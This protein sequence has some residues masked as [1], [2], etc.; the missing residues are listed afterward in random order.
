MDNATLV[1]LFQTETDPKKLADLMAEVDKRLDRL[2]GH[3]I[4]RIKAQHKRQAEE[5][6]QII[7]T[8]KVG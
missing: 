7:D 1:R 6:T 5:V 2:E 3:A 4:A 8:R